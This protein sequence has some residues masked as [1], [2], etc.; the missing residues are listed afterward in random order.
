MMTIDSMAQLTASEL[1]ER[2]L[3]G[4]TGPL[5]ADTAKP[6]QFQEAFALQQ[7]VS[8]TYCQLSH[9]QIQ[10]WK[11]ALPVGEKQ[12]LGP[13]FS[14][15]CVDAAEICPI[16]PSSQG[17]ARVEPELVFTLAQD[18]PSRSAPY[19]HA[20]IDAAIGST[21]LALELIQSRYDNPKDATYF[22]ALADGLVN[23]GLYLGPAVSVANGSELSQ[24]TLTITL[25][26]SNNTVLEK[27]AEHPNIDPRAG[28]YWLVNFLSS[29]GLTLSAGQHVITG[30]YA[31][32]LDLPLDTHT[33]IRFGELGSITTRFSGKS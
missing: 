17:L 1:A 32:V 23:Q 6:T 14:D 26:D 20:E 3:H 4:R 24:F 28:L 5:L 30:S 7:A 2:R 18:L 11:C 9:S 29:Q 27:A 25:D 16:W 31:G 33:E 22:E 13:L 8:Q 19:T 15:A 10:G 12:I 21:R